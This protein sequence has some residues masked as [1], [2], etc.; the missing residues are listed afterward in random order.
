MCA[1]LVYVIS[2]LFGY[3]EGAFTGT[4]KSGKKGLFEL[5]HNGTIFLDEIGDSSLWI[6]SRLLRVLEEKEIMRLGDTKI[7][8]V[9]IRLIAATNKDLKSLVAENRFR[10]DLYYRLNTFQLH[11]DPLRQR[12]N[13]IPRLANIFLKKYNTNKT[14]S[15]EAMECLANYDWPGNIREFKNMIEYSVLMA[16]SERIEPNSLPHDIRSFNVP[17]ISSRKTNAEIEEICYR[18]GNQYNLAQIKAVLAILSK[19]KGINRIGR[20]SMVLLLARYN[21]IVT[22]G[23]LRTLFKHLETLG[24]IA[25]GKTKQGTHLTF[26]GEQVL[27]YI[28]VPSIQQ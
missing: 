7:I 6:Q 14:F 26:K 2:E 17:R 18:L 20:N 19:N 4:K 13:S 12:K 10:A 8:P 9:N 1:T 25:S 16:K 22:V 28:A 11:I 15:A 21:I 24:L 27:E 23:T 3:S 5:A